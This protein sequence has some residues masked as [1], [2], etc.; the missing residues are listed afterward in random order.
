MSSHF[1]CNCF[2]V[3]RMSLS[4]MTSA[5]VRLASTRLG[6]AALLK[7]LV[8][9]EEIEEKMSRTVEDDLLPSRF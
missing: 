4:E 7:T 9:I 5:D 1:S 6:E 8:E 3:S 2:P